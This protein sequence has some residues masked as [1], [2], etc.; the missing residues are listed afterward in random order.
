MLSA[1][2][3][4]PAL[5][6]DASAAVVGDTQALRPY[7][8][9]RAGC[10]ERR[11]Q[12]LLRSCV[13][14][15]EWA[16]YTDLGFIAVRGRVVIAP[17]GGTPQGLAAPGYAYLI[18]A[19]RPIVAYV[20]QTGRLLGEYCIAFRDSEHA[21]DR[22]PPSDDVLA[23]WLALVADERELIANANLH[24]AGRQLDPGRVR[25]D[26]GALAAWERVRHGHPPGPP[27]SVLG[28]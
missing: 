5:P 8:H 26:L 4:S 6:A 19:Y 15:E 2:S 25:R 9:V 28:P 11:A 21:A 22:L 7:D 1:S 10:A 24:P 23:K 17:S 3:S 12:A 27:D 16:M 13:N 14:P 20:P 18:Y